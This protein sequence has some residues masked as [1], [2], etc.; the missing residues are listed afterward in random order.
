MT[1]TL[2]DMRRR[3]QQRDMIRYTLV[4]VERLLHEEPCGDRERLQRFLAYLC[5]DRA[6]LEELCQQEMSSLRPMFLTEFPA[7]LARAAEYVRGGTH[8]GLRAQRPEPGP[9]PPPD[10]SLSS[11][12]TIISVTFSFVTTRSSW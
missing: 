10:L 12:S 4:E 11:S 2:W 8:V 9:S 6:S 1:S 5:C 7:A 3:A